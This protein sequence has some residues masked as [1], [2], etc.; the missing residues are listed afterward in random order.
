MTF[1]CT[2]HCPFCNNRRAECI[3]DRSVNPFFCEG[4]GRPEH[5]SPEQRLI[6]DQ[7]DDRDMAIMNRMAG[8]D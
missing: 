7:G 8:T 2:T 3:C 1:D 5:G 6:E 4:D